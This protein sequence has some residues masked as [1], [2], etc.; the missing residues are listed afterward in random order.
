MIELSFSGYIPVLGYNS[1]VKVTGQNIEQAL[2]DAIKA[3]DYLNKRKRLFKTSG[4]RG[5]A[6]IL[7]SENK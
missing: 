7:V 2:N 6:G 5:E 1:T 3:R 4:T